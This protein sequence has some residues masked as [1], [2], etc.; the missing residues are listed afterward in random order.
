MKG[1]SQEGRQEAQEQRRHPHG[2]NFFL[3]STFD[4]KD[5]LE[6]IDI[7]ALPMTV[8]KYHDT[9]VIGTNGQSR[10]Y[11]HH[12]TQIVSKQEHCI[13]Q[14]YQSALSRK[15]SGAKCPTCRASSLDRCVNSKLDTNDDIA[16]THRTSTF[17]GSRPNLTFFTPFEFTRV[18]DFGDSPIFRWDG[19]RSSV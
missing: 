10:L 9:A 19:F 16:W 17:A 3:A 11:P 6:T 7:F 14:S 18:A 4:T 1:P 15:K 2:E 5:L 13:I 8:N 12:H